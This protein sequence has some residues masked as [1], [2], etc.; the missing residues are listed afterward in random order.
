MKTENH[1]GIV[2]SAV[3]YAEKDKIVTLLTLDGKKVVF[4][5]RGVNGEKAK[6]RF[7][8]QIFALCEVE[9]SVSARPILVGG[10]SKHMF[11]GV[12]ESV[13]KFYLA[14]YALEETTEEDGK[15]LL[16]CLTF[17]EEWEY[18][19]TLC[20]KFICEVQKHR[21]IGIFADGCVSCGGKISKKY[22]FSFDAGGF[23]CENCG[24]ED[25]GALY[26]TFQMVEKEGMQ[27]LSKIKFTPAQTS[28]LFE[29]LKTHGEFASGERS[30]SLR[31]L[32][33]G[34]NV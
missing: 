20:C 3:D 33:E 9:I 2:I 13:E 12:R 14:C 30:K 6:L 18:S 26:K 23:L 5:A 16:S 28:A 19:Q 8:G 15:F 1:V 31:G 24:G 21:G 11:W 25:V 10:V 27:T 29:L 17:L 34:F 22:A 7:A 4:R 32:G